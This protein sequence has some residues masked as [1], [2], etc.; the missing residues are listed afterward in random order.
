MASLTI[1]VGPV[2]STLTVSDATATDVLTRVFLYVYVPKEGEPAAANMTQKQ[3]LDWL[4]KWLGDQLV[5]TARRARQIEL[6]GDA[7][8]T[9][10]T[11]L[12]KIALS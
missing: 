8:A 9:E 6:A 3:R 4:T 2:T 5:A 1:T 10:R 11:E 7:A 12:A